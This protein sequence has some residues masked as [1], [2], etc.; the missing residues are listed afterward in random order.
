[1]YRYFKAKVKENIPLGSR[2]NLLSIKPLD[3]I[4]EPSPGQFY[5]IEV[6]TAYDPLLKRP[7]SYLRRSADAIQFLYAVKGKGTAL[8][9]TFQQG[10][11]INIIGPLGN[12]YPELEDGHTPLLAAGGIGIASLF[13]LAEKL[14][15]KAHVFYG[16]KCKA[17]LLMLHELGDLGI[18]L[19]TCTDDC[20][21]GMKGMVGDTLKAFVTHNKF[22]QARYILYACGPRPMLESVSKIAFEKGIKGYVSLE[23]NMACGFGACQGCAVK[24]VNGYQRVCK[25]GPIFPIGEIVWT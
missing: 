17:D 20:S 21:F 16:A 11:I 5:M 13:P 25:E 2:N 6:G 19:I 18:E 12:A 3:P 8:M 23:E 9:K 4:I 14:G 1:L 7:F 10:K 24:T 15:R 22:L